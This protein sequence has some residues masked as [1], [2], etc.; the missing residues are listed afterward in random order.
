MKQPGRN[1]K[2]PC[3][4]GHKYK[5][6]CGAPPTEEQQARLAKLKDMFTPGG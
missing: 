2:C 4:S 1:E 3:G 6:C 5:K